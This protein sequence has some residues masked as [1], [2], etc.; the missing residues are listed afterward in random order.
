MDFFRNHV[1]LL[2]AILLLILTTVSGDLAPTFGICC[3][4][5]ASWARDSQQCSTFPTSIHEL[6]TEH[7]S[8]CVTAARICCLRYFR[9]EQCQKGSQAAQLGQDCAV[10]SSQ[11]GE[12]FKD[13]CQAC[14]LGIFSGSMGMGCGTNFKFGFPWDNAYQDCCNQATD[15]ENLYAGLQ[16]SSHG[17]PDSENLCKQLPGKLCS[18]LCVPTP[19]S[20]RCM[21]RPGFTLFTD[22]KTCIQD[23]VTDRCEE[24]NPCD[25]ICKDTGVSI[26]CSCNPGFILEADQKSCEDVDECE[27][28]SHNCNWTTHICVNTQGGYMCQEKSVSSE[29]VAG[30]K[31]SSQQQ[32]CIDIDECAENSDSCDRVIQTC[33]NSQG[34]FRCI[35][36]KPSCDFGYRYNEELQSCVDIDECEENRDICNKLTE[37]CV[38]SEGNYWCSLILKTPAPSNQHI[39]TSSTTTTTLRPPPLPSLPPRPDPQ[40]PLGTEY[41][42]L[43]KACVDIDECATNPCKAFEVCENSQG[44]YHC[45]CIDGYS[46]DEP[47]GD[48]EDMNEC[49]LGLHTCTAAQRCDNT[50]GSYACIRIAGCGTGY[51]LNHNTGECDDNDE[52]KLNT[53]DCNQRG[54]I[55][56]CVNT[57]GSFRCKIKTC[58][59]FHELNDEGNCVAFSCDVGYRPGNVSCVDIDECAE[60]NPCRQNERCTNTLGS[61]TCQPRLRCFAGYEMNEAGTQC[62]DIDECAKGTHQCVGNEVC[63]NRQGSYVCFCP[64]G[65]RRN[66]QRQCADINECESYHGRVCGNN[67][68]CENTEGS[69]ICKCKAGFKQAANGLSCVDVNECEETPGICQHNC[70]N[71]WGSYY[72]TCNAG[73]VLNSDN[74]TCSDVDECEKARNRGHLC[75]GLCVNVPG[76]FKCTC[77]DGYTLAADGRTCK[78]NNE[79]DA[80]NVCRGIGEQ[81]INT[82]GG[83]KC[84][85]ITCPDNYVRDSRRENRCE[86]LVSYC[87]VGDDT[88]RLKPLSYSYNFLP[89]AS[90]L[91]LPSVG[92]VDI[93]TM[94]GPLWSTTTVQFELKLEYVEASPEIAAVT[95]D[96]F[97]L[98]RTAYNQAVLSLV[99]PIIGPQ[100]VQLSLNMKLYQ[101]GQFSGTAVAKLLLYVSEYNF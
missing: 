74:S 75:I 48:C 61:Y 53:H 16:G 5:G 35:D 49:Q 66:A 79:C 31:F 59:P 18:D 11:G 24:N 58:P 20:Y 60:D 1:R 12:Y 6:P 54:A 62:V 32:K 47:D 50:A 34:S 26:V 51:T 57:R 25:H 68:D 67:A 7:Q 64:R 95:R 14:K 23:A 33:I 65:F 52:C 80:G 85:T 93:F 36:Q 77:P 37:R 45:R 91:T 41:N 73:Y 8:I 42:H 55:Y 92:E 96:F 83:Y 69:F 21:C 98:K 100:E 56:Q 101:Q 78:D 29:C 43:T 13:C 99:K 89:L 19:G 70:I 4:H 9:N 39:T 86:R 81:C 28:D 63:S 40:C 82:R 27:D 22:G 84:N 90:N 72:C 71:V 97:K 15:N 30:Y 2:V 88:C 10:S 87:P 3:A 76:S 17:I 46:R 38:N 44:S 94:R